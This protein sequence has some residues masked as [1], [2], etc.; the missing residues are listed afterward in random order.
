MC[1]VSAL[2]HS[3][4]G[5]H[6]KLEYDEYITVMSEFVLALATRHRAPCCERTQRADK[7]VD[8]DDLR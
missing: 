1:R 2:T 3:S 5:V 8:S 7:K 4:H 6:N